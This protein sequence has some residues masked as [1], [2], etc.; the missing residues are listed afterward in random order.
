MAKNFEEIDYQETPIGPIILQRRRIA[1]LENLDVYEVKLGE[2]YL[3]SSLFHAS[4]D[5]LA[6]LGLKCCEGKALDIIVGG[7]GLGYTAAKILEDERVKSLVVVDALEAVIGWHQKG[8][9]PLGKYLVSDPRCQL[10]KGDFFGMAVDSKGFAPDLPLQKAHAILV[11][12]DHSP[13][14]LLNPR[15]KSFYT[16]DGLT[17]LS[18][19]LHKNGVF[20][21]W[22]NELPEE[23]FL[24]I[25]RQVFVECEARV[26]EFDNPLQNSTAKNTIYLGKK[27][28]S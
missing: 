22:S 6:E 27:C 3:M 14:N 8:L 10:I 23:D 2:E 5:A 18:R 26:I 12:I 9:V 16:V 13:T 28:N 1:M 20:G 4:E 7:L 11:D 17:K 21:L 15:S 19:H 25:L 24:K